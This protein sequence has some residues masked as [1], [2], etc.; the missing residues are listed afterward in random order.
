MVEQEERTFS[1]TYRVGLNRRMVS[2]I[3]SSESETA[4]AGTAEWRCPSELGV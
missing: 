4:L 2:G 3:T 1:D